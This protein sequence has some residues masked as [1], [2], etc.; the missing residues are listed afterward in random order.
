MG[1]LLYP[2]YVGSDHSNLLVFPYPYILYRSDKLE[3]DKEGL[4]KELFSSQ[5]FSIKLSLAG[6]LPI[7]SSGAREGMPDL[8]PSGEIGPAFVYTFYEENALSL[9]LGVPVRAVFSTDLKTVDY[10]GFIS[11]IRSE[12]EYTTENNYLFQLYTGFAFADSRYN[13][14]LYGVDSQF[15]NNNREEYHAKGGYSAFQT[16]VGLSKD[17]KKFWLGAFLKHQVLTNSSFSNSPLVRRNSALY[18]GFVLAY[19]F[20]KSFSN[21]VKKWLED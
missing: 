20:D 19:K 10:R 11:Q 18:G 15:V 8:D 14:Y 2:D 5:D 17:F 3:I 1:S 16:A 12:F 13:N 9:K 21:R 6:S 4:K 7:S